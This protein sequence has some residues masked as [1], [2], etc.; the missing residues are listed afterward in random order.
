VAQ[1]SVV[2]ARP[3]PLHPLNARHTE[4]MAIVAMVQTQRWADAM[5]TAE[6]ARQLLRE[7]QLPVKV[8][9]T[10][11]DGYAED[12]ESQEH[13]MVAAK[14]CPPL[15]PCHR[16]DE[17][18]PL[19]PEQEQSDEAV[20]QGVC[21]APPPPP[22][23][24]CPPRATSAPAAVAGFDDQTPTSCAGSAAASF[25]SAQSALEV[26]IAPLSDRKPENSIG[27]ELHGM[28]ECKPCAW[29]W[30]PQGCSNG[31]EC[32]H[33]HMCYQGAFKTR[34][35]AKMVELRSA[36][37]QRPVLLGNTRPPV[38]GAEKLGRRAIVAPM[39]AQ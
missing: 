25:S 15:G 20:A 1:D 13:P 21:G 8:K 7:A 27:S 10:F 5:E 17:L 22:N 32:R 37:A 4:K 12:E 31:E 39:K 2:R 29:F 36:K 24:R 30:R 11:I 3:S 34:K 38:S 23:A 14:T 9:N 19:L 33:C 28:G 16:L 35:K 26:V 18:E 6:A